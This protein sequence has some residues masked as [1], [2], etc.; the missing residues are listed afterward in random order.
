M[1]EN[2]LDTAGDVLIEY[3]MNARG[4]TGSFV[5]RPFAQPSDV[6]NEEL[7]NGPIMKKLVQEDPAQVV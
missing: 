4:I 5:P 6:Q 2:R 1:A 7:L 3:L